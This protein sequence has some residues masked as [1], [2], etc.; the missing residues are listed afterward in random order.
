MNVARTQFG[1]CVLE[2]NIYIFCG[3]TSQNVYLSSIECLEVEFTMAKQR[4]IVNTWQLAEIDEDEFPPRISMLVAPLNLSEIL[5]LG[6]QKGR[7][8]TDGYI[9][10]VATMN[11]D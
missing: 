8:L 3:R 5:I 6:G 4:R 9:F 11:I 2:N 1:S 10:N 7:P